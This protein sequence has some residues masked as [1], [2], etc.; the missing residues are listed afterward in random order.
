[1]NEAVII[2]RA[3]AL[4]PF[5]GLGETVAALLK[6]QTAI[7][8]GPCF[9]VAAA[10]APFADVR[11]RNLRHCAAHLAKSLDLGTLDH[12]STVFVNGSAKGD[13]H[14]LEE[15][16][17]GGAAAVDVSPFLDIQTRQAYEALHFQPGRTISISN[18]CASGAIALELAKELL[19]DGRCGAAVLFGIESICKFVA[20]GFSALSALSPSGARPFDKRRDGLS[21]GEAA[22]LAVISRRAPQP[23]DIIV[24]GAGSSN[25]ANHRTGPSR[26][27]EGLYRAAC[28]ALRDASIGPADVGAVKCHGTATLYNDAMEAKAIYRLFGDTCPPCVSF[29]GAMGHTSGAGSLVEI[30]IAAQCLKRKT[31]PPTARYA[32]HGVD[33]PIAVSNTTQT[34]G[35]PTALCLSA[36]FGGVNA[37]VVVKEAG[38]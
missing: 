4:T 24:S 5:G 20:T 25:D 6:G 35:K 28:E 12:R 22:V 2:E 11:L 38:G 13:I 19:E 16:V 15:V 36:G 3:A 30:L 33:E 18:A 9:D 23:G 10:C 31:L 1:M 17:E 34:V 29:K 32:Q 26:T 7:R 8:P 37:A 14:S 21:L 27:G